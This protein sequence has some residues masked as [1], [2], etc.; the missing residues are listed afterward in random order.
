MGSESEPKLTRSRRAAREAALKAA[1]QIRIGGVSPSQALDDVLG[2]AHLAPEGED[3]VRR[4]VAETDRQ[5]VEI[6]ARIKPLLAAGWDFER[7]AEIDRAI[8]RLACAE[9]YGFPEIPP[10]ATISEAVILAKRYGTK[11]SGRFVNGVLASLLAQSPKASWTAPHALDEFQ[12]E[13][14]DE[15]PVEVIEEG[16]PEHRDL[17]GVW[18][19]R[20]P[21]PANDEEGA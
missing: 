21:P 15:P 17:V 18:K 13:Q 8:L 6:D 16:S 14:E 12:E 1:Y 5:I 2:E 19:L 10:K 9:L 7:L 3:F 4:L 11:E 20:T